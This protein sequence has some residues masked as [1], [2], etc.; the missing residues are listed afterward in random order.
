M[1]AI[2]RSNKAH[3]QDRSVAQTTDFGL[4]YT[5]YFKLCFL[6]TLFLSMVTG[7]VIYAFIKIFFISLPMESKVFFKYIARALV[8][9]RIPMQRFNNSKFLLPLM[10]FIREK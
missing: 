10:K 4:F 2:C 6:F 1:K 8:L 3:L 9:S 7:T 5:A